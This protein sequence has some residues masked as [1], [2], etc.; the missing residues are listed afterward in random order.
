MT[1]DESFVHLWVSSESRVLDLACG[2][3]TLLQSLRN[4]QKIHGYGLEIDPKSIQKCIEKDINVI[5]QD[6]N[7]GLSN[8][9]DNS[10]DSVIMMQ[11]L[12]VM[13]D[14]HLVLDEM[15][16]IGRECI[17]TFPNFGH[18]RT[19]LYLT[20]KGQ[21][22]VT[23]QLAYQWYDTPNIHL[24]TCADFEVLCR[25]R[26]IRILHRQHIAEGLPDC[27]I[28]DLWPNLY[29]ETAIYHLSR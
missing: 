13:R 5:E 24:F 28:K 17:V 16:R 6:L 8:F 20:L 21:M 12:Q 10:F 22:P 29:T 23:L 14:P 4:N 18:W 25:Q 9:A 15:L 3:G 27:Y 1:T 19:R 26:N 11:A 2:D 7:S